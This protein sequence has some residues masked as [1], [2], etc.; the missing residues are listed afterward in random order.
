MPDGTLWP[1]CGVLFGHDGQEGVPILAPQYY[2]K[3]TGATWGAAK[4]RFY[5]LAP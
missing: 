2:G 4:V 3:P 1:V 5:W